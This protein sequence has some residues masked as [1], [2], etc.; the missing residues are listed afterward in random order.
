MPETAKQVSRKGPQDA[1]EAIRPTWVMRHPEYIKR[2]LGNDQQRLY[3]LIWQ[4]FVASQMSPAVF[5]VVGVDIAAR[6]MVFRATGSTVTFQGFMKV[7][8]EGKDDARTVSDE[9][10][11]RFRQ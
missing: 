3:K 5:D 10:S 1:H 2:H 7:Y 11:L 8:T 4:R 6:N 9:D